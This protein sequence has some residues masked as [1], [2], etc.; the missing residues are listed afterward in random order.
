M[1]LAAAFIKKGTLCG[2]AI[3]NFDNMCLQQAHSNR[4]AAPHA[5]GSFFALFLYVQ[6]YVYGRWRQPDGLELCTGTWWQGS[7]ML[8]DSAVMGN[9]WLQTSAAVQ[10]FFPVAEHS[11][12]PDLAYYH[13]LWH[14]SPLLQL[15]NGQ[16]GT[17]LTVGC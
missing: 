13:H 11:T 17:M 1:A 9:I 15:L 10:M 3:S 4:F 6:L 2:T 14:L 5:S 16:W 12:G 7:P 8:R